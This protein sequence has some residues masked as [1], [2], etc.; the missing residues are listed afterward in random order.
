MS[1][2]T[3]SG[4]FQ[5]RDGWQSFEKQIEAEN[6]NVAEEHIL[7]EFGSRHGL[8]RTQIEVEGVDA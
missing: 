4:R 6:E 3:V 1:E 8:K 7:S 5:A 2:F